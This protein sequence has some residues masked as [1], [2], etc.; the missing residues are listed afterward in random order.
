MTVLQAQADPAAAL[1]VE[2]PAEDL[3]V[4][5]AVEDQVEV[6]AKDLVVPGAVADLVA[7]APAAGGA[8]ATSRMNN[9]GTVDLLDMRSRHSNFPLH[10]QT[11][12][13]KYV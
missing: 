13:S 9:C 10:Y 12:S 8:A 5:A 4:P 11:M 1:P 6:P 7:Q 2:V 3:V